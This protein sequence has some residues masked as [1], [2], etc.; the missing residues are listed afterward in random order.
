MHL[1]QMEEVRSFDAASVAFS[2]AAGVG[3][4]VAPT[5]SYSC[6]MQVHHTKPSPVAPTPLSFF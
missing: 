5:N 1:D 3:V 6:K 2:T 4:A